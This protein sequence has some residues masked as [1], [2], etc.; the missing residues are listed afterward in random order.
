VHHARIWPLYSEDSINQACTYLRSRGVHGFASD[1]ASSSILHLRRCPGRHFRSVNLFCSKNAK[2]NLFPN[3]HSDV[4]GCPSSCRSGAVPPSARL[5]IPSVYADNTFL[6]LRTIQTLSPKS[7]QMR[8]MNS[9]R[10]RQKRGSVTVCASAVR[11][12]HMSEK[13]ERNF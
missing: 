7:V 8:N 5:T 6:D 3:C 2:R 9:V 4:G 12:V 10:W 13:R 11:S 1:S